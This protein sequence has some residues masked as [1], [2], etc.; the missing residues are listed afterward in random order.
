MRTRFGRGRRGRGG[1]RKAEPIDAVRA[2]EALC[3]GE[4]VPAKQLQAVTLDEVPDHFAALGEGE[5]AEGTPLLVAYAPGNAGDAVLAAMALATERSQETPFPGEVLAVAPQWSAAARGRLALIGKLP[6]A[7]R[8]VA[9]SALDAGGGTVEPERYAPPLPVLPRRLAELCPGPD[10]AQLF[11]RALSAL[12]GLAAKHGGAVRGT[13]GGAELVLMARRCALLRPDP[14]GVVLETLEPD[15]ATVTLAGD[16]L[17]AALDRL[18]GALRK[19]LN[20]RKVKGGE[21]GMRALAIPRMVQVAALQAAHIWPLGGSDPEVIDVVGLDASGRPVVG[22]IRDRLDLPGLAL[23][24]DGFVS[25]RPLLGGIIGEVVGPLRLAEPRLA[26]AAEQVDAVIGRVLGTFALEH[27]VYALVDPRGTPDVV[28]RDSV[29]GATA[30]DATSDEGR[31]DRPRRRRRGGRRGGRNANGNGA[32]AEEPAAAAVAAVASEPSEESAEADMEEISLFDLDDDAG[33]NDDENGSRRRRRRGRRRGGRRRSEGD[34]AE[35]SGDDG[36]RETATADEPAAAD[37]SPAEDEDDL[38]DDDPDAVLAPISDD[39]ME[40][41]AAEPDYDDEEESD[42]DA[43]DEWMAE[44]EARRRARA[45]RAPRERDVTVDEGPKAPPRRRS[46][47][48]VHADP[49]SVMAGVLL[50]RDIRM[51]EGFWVY[52][53]EDLMTFFRGVATDLRQETPIYVVGFSARP[54]RDT[55]QAAALYAGR[56]VWF[57]HHDWPPEDLESMRSTI[58]NENVEIDPGSGSSIPGVL[59]R[60]QRRSRFSD[61]LVELAT[62]RFSQHDYERWGRVWSERVRKVASGTGE[63]RHT[64]DP[65]LIGR[66]SELAKEASRVDIPPAPAELGYVSGRDFRVVHFGGLGLVVVPVPESMDPHLTARL[67]R[68]RFDAPVSLAYREGEELVLLG[69]DEGRGPGGLDLGAMV[70]HLDA[71]YEWITG[72]RDDDHVAR[73]RV[74]DMALRPERLDELVAEVAMG[75]SLLDG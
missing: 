38:V 60:R 56:L 58:G 71:K 54:A 8:A 4:H 59:A 5:T 15:R 49:D 35:A 45:K 55:I 32:A 10:A 67:A 72:L 66:P 30:A 7:F 13:S 18:E 28:H 51:I 50:A 69:G 47:I 75:R 63:Q 19:R 20:D 14:A 16:G 48:V 23:L 17:A 1:E 27:D 9:V 70:S 21:E 42:E 36:G 64:V 37:T 52:P 74:R 11:L 39:D 57:D 68:E 44:R 53:Q 12:E 46:A 25:M 43:P 31:G 6:F 26:F 34:A 2:F 3:S 29:T 62:G 40:V 24:L 41:P 73:M 22:A 33:G 61:K 65:L